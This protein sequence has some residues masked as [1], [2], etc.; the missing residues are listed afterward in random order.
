MG[1]RYYENM[2]PTEEVPGEPWNTHCLDA[3]ADPQAV[4]DG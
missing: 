4:K 1:N 2:N 3:T